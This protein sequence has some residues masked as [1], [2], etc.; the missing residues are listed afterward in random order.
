MNFIVR[1]LLASCLAAGIAGAG[2]TP[3]PEPAAPPT[4]YIRAGHL[5]DAT[6][7]NLRENVVLVVDGERITKVAPAGDVTIPAGATV[8]DLSKDWVL[9]G[10]ID[11]HTHLEFRA[12]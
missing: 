3:A 1:L 7:D 12:D 4:V 6:T 11:C 8:L 2:K 5:F 10:L 9:P